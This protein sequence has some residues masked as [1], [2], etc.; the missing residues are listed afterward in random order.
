MNNKYKILSIVAIILAM[1]IGALLFS[2]LYPHLEAR[3]AAAPELTQPEKV[4]SIQQNQACGS[5]VRY[6]CPNLTVV[7]LC[8]DPAA[9]GNYLGVIMTNGG[10]QSVVKSAYSAPMGDWLETINGCEKSLY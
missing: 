6:V 4:M 3:P 1:A 5:I 7:S 8:V 10:S 9:P 2:V